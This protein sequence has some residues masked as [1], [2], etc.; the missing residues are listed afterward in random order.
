MYEVGHDEPIACTRNVQLSASL[1]SSGQSSM[2]DDGDMKVVA[3]WDKDK[4]AG[5][6]RL[7]SAAGRDH[8]VGRIGMSRARAN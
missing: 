1:R 7:A 5:A 8:G 6:I 4:D 2:I 3:A